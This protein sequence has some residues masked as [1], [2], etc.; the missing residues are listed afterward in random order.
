MT[1]RIRLIAFLIVCLIALV[2]FS[3]C[4]SVETWCDGHPKSCAVAATVGTL[5]VAVAA[6]VV[7]HEVHKGV[8]NPAPKY[9]PY[10]AA[11]HAA[12]ATDTM[13]DGMRKGQPK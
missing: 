12:K 8:A 5:C 1:L 11:F 3:G 9:T 4:T 2:A 7:V 6:G 10:V 13:L